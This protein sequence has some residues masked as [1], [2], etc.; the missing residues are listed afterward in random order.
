MSSTRSMSKATRLCLCLLAA[1]AGEAQLM[2]RRRGGADSSTS[3][4]MRTCALALSTCFQGEPTFQS[5]TLSCIQYWRVSSPLVS[6]SNT[7]S[8]VVRM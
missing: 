5:D 3:P 7:F 2:T 6:A 8:G 1:S 4:T